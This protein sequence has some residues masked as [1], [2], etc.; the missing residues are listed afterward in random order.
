MVFTRAVENRK[1]ICRY[2]AATLL[3]EILDV[4]DLRHVLA[5]LGALRPSMLFIDPVVILVLVVKRFL[6]LVSERKPESG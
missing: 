3:Q 6:G 5:G 2:L 4:P 1:C